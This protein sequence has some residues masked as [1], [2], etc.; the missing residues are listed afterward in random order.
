MEK[1]NLDGTNESVPHSS[2]QV[3]VPF[4]VT[5]FRP[6]LTAE[7]EL[8]IRQQFHDTWRWNGQVMWSGILREE[9]QE[10]ADN[11][12][13]ATLT[14]AMG[15]LMNPEHTLCL[16]NNKTSN[17]WS[18]YVKGASAVFAWHIL[19]GERVVVL[20][21]PP[22][23][24]FHPSGQT[25]YQAIE[26]RILKSEREGGTRLRIYMVHPLVKGAE[27][28]SY[29]VWP[30]DETNTWI[31]KFGAQVRGARAWRKVKKVPMKIGI[32]YTVGCANEGG[33]VA[34]ARDIK[35]EG[36]ASGVTIVK[37]M[38]KKKKTKV[39]ENKKKKKEKREKTEKVKK[40]KEA[41]E[42]EKATK[43]RREKKAS[44]DQARK[45]KKASKKKSISK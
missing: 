33:P 44:K 36:H 15:P 42:K 38:L 28:F 8:Q 39:E 41:K 10:W 34:F 19:R 27:D 20:S 43:E 35:L 31:E 40:K 14:T 2:Y 26:E 12:D 24:R 37:K 17:A 11:H 9:A 13:M 32:S 25:N 22:P 16:K 5:D 45:A 4:V 18:K 6:Y 1:E 21:P 23:E 3:S 30:V 29:Q 7:E